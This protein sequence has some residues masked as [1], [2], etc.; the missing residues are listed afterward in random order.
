M[1]HDAVGPG[2]E[3]AGQITK[4][5]QQGRSLN[6][7]ARELDMPAAALREIAKGLGISNRTRQRPDKP[8]SIPEVI[9]NVRNAG[10]VQAANHLAAWYEQR[11]QRTLAAARRSRARARRRVRVNN[12]A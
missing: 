2:S 10:H 11:R 12:G 4:L 1:G 9:E 7:I 5:R 6:A 3:L 8:Y